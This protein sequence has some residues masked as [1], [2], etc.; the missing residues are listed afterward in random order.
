[1]YDSAMRSLEWAIMWTPR[2]AYADAVARLSRSS[3]VSA[4]GRVIVASLIL[5]ATMATTITLVAD[6]V[7][8]LRAA[9]TWSFAIVVQIAAAVVLVASSPR[10]RVGG[11]RAFDLLWAASGPWTL[12]LAG[13][14]AWVAA[15]R[16][17]ALELHQAI[18]TLVMPGAWTTYL[19][20]VC[21]REVLNHSTPAALTRAA[22]HQAFI[23]LVGA[24]YFFW[25]VQGWPRLIGL[26]G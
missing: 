7:V 25:A 26:F 4:A 1:M 6:S 5:G 16:A 8:V 10:R 2:R 13:F 22:I 23:W 20:F 12:W 17:G 15:S 24:G 11:V 18:V 3:V 19:V 9:L 14:T 21:C